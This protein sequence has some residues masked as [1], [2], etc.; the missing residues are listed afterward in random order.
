MRNREAK[1]RKLVAPFLLDEATVSYGAPTGYYGNFGQ[2]D[3]NYKDQR[4]FSPSPPQHTFKQNN[5]IAD[6]E[7]D[8]DGYE[9]GDEMIQQNIDCNIQMLEAEDL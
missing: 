3:L 1:S 6:D 2:S 4:D 9:L 5:V 7:D 8:D